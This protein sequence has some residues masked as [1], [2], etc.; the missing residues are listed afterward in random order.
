MTALARLAVAAAAS[1]IVCACA[2]GAP[3]Q[4]AIVV[5]SAPVSALGSSNAIALEPGE[6][7]EVRST[8]A[9]ADRTVRARLRYA[10][11]IDEK[12]ERHVVVYDGQGLPPNGKLARGGYLSFAALN[13]PG[14]HYD[15][16]TGELIAPLVVPPERQVVAR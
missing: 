10:I 5:R 2:H 14:A 6:E 1:G 12:G 13:V 16:Q 9:G 4:P 7:T 15:P 8:V 11:A 3:H